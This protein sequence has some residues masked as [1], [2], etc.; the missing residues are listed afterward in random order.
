MLRKTVRSVKGD[1]HC[2]QCIDKFPDLVGAARAQPL[3]VQG[4]NCLL[5]TLGCV[6]VCP[7]LLLIACCT[8]LVSRSPSNA[9]HSVNHRA[10]RS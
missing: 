9:C 4:G 7:S 8:R 2:E 3:L 10:L 6:Y 5:R 1:P